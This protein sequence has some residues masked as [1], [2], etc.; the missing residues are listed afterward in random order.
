MEDGHV[1][2]ARARKT[3]VF[4]AKTMLV[5]ASN[6][7]PCGYFRDKE[8]QCTCTPNEISKY[9]KKISGPLLDR[10]D[11]QVWT[12]RIKSEDFNNKD[13]ENSEDIKKL[14]NNARKL[15]IERYKNAGL[16]TI[17]NS[18]LSS[19]QIEK[20]LNVSQESKAILDKALDNAIITAR[21]FFKTIKLAQTI[22]DLENRGRIEKNDIAEALSYR[23]Q[24][25]TI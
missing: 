6:P 7:C 8:R 18:E 25:E 5:A 23:I 15:Q 10:I 11:I 21:G 2:I 3:L 22:A 24:Q 1:T 14:V 4:P 20:I 9:Q 16:P 13:S 12:K 17:S 19:K